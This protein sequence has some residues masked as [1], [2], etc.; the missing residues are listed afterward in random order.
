[1][2]ILIARIALSTLLLMATPALAQEQPPG[3][4]RNCGTIDEVRRMLTEKYHEAVVGHGVAAAGQVLLTVYASADGATW[5]IVMTRARDGMA[6]ITAE[7][8]DWQFSEPA[9]GEGL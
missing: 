6:C 7:G 5:S 9:M 1:M 2:K 8:T 3:Q 4:T